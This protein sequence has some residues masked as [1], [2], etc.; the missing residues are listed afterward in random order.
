MIIMGNFIKNSSTNYANSKGLSG[1]CGVNDTLRF[2]GKRWQM[3]I[4]Y[5]ISLGNDQ[6]SSLKKSLHVISDHILASRISDLLSQGLITRGEI[7]NSVP[8][9]ILY[10]V[11]EK[12]KELLELM[13]RLQEWGPLAQSEKSK[14]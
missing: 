5:E 6:F 8:S 9:Q 2:I 4:L 14:V 11:T 12:G 1:K 13:N 3:A 10:S 7:E